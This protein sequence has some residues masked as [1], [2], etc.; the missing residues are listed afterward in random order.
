MTL[1]WQARIQ[2]LP[3]GSWIV[4]SKCGEDMENSV[5]YRAALIGEEQG[6]SSLEAI[7]KQRDSATSGDP[8]SPQS[9]S[10]IYPLR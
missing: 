5:S 6:M 10:E 3:V 2:S 9:G 7:S 4:V 1:H 8:I